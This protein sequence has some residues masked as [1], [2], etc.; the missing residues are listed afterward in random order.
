MVYQSI[1]NLFGQHRPLRPREL[2][3]KGLLSLSRRELGHTERGPTRV[4]ASFHL[5]PRGDEEATRS[6]YL[7]GIQGTRRD[8][9]RCVEAVLHP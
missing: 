2:N 7:R 5:S 8:P 4:H 9:G 1:N 6:R 3:N